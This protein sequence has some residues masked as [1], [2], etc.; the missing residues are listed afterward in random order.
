MT[1]MSENNRANEQQTLGAFLRK[2]RKN[3]NLS[4]AD[5]QS[6]TR[7]ST[8]NLKAMENDDYASMPAD[9]FCRGF[10]VIYAQLLGLDSDEILNRYLDS[11]GIPSSPSQDHSQP[12]VSKSDK[13]SNFAEPSLVSPR[14]GLTIILVIGLIATIG[15]SWYFNFNPAAYI[16]TTLTSQEESSPQAEIKNELIPPATPQKLEGD[17]ASDTAAVKETVKET[18]NNAPV[19]D[20]LAI[21]FRNAGTLTVTRNDG[22]SINKHYLSGQTMRWEIKKSMTIDMPEGIDADILLNGVKRPLPS[23]TNGRRLLSLPEDPRN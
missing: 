2:S 3:K 21:T 6:A 15:I 9:A 23:I 4:L 12:P 11:R 19:P 13:F 14:S 17:K 20:H 18:T 22:L 1:R 16:S 8:P 5:I 7:I 10:Y